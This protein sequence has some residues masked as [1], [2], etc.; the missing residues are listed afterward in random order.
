MR[1]IRW[2]R[3]GCP[4]PPSTGA[5]AWPP[6]RSHRR[7]RGTG[8]RADRVIGESCDEPID[9]LE[10]R[11][12]GDVPERLEGLERA[13]LLP[14]RL[15]H[16]LAA[17]PDVGVPE[18]RGAVE[19]APA[20]VV[21]EVDALAARDHELV[22]RDGRHVGERVPVRAGRRQRADRVE[23]SSRRVTLGAGAAGVK[24]EP[25]AR[26][27][28]MLWHG[29]AGS[30]ARALRR[31]AR[32]RAAHALAADRARGGF[33]ARARDRGAVVRFHAGT[34][35]GGRRAGWARSAPAP[36]AARVERRAARQRRRAPRGGHPGHATARARRALLPRGRAGRR[37]DGRRGLGRRGVREGQRVPRH[38]ARRPARHRRLAGARLPAG[39][40]AG[41]GRRRCCGVSAPLLR[42][43]RAR[44]T[45]IHDGD[46]RC[47]SRTCPAAAR[48][49][50][51]RHL[52]QL[53]RRHA[54]AGSI[55]AASRA[56][57]APRRSTAASL[58][59][60]PVYEL[61]ARNA[62]RALRVQ[63]AR[64]R[65][66]P[67]LPAGFPDTRA[68]LARVLARHPRTADDLATAIAVLLRSPEDAARVP[69]LVHEAA[70]GRRGAAGSREFAAHVGTR[71]RRALAPA[72]VLDHDP[73]N[74]RWARFDVAATA[75]RAAGAILA[76]AAVARAK[77]FRQA[78][79]AVP[80]AGGRGRA[81]RS[82]PCRPCRSCCSRATPIRR[83]RRRT[84]AGW[85]AD[86]PQRPARQ[87]ARPGARRDRL[88]LPA[89]PRRAL[90]RRAAAPAGST[91]AARGACRCRASSSASECAARTGR[92]RAAR[93]PRAGRDP[94][95]G[96]RA[97]HA[98]GRGD[99]ERSARAVDDASGDA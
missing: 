86:V 8:T 88:R 78:C 92:A 45:P 9:E 4:W 10:R 68:E 80:R 13:Q 57:C 99:E 31:A 42:A 90:R 47:R 74:E 2:M 50:P 64:C 7:R 59:S 22:A 71:A 39:A 3:S 54:R 32:R 26:L 37:G 46:R 16:V 91:R 85:R 20:L 55:C 76:H 36:T 53:L 41:D 82:E 5:R 58:P 87:R 89:P 14:D 83:I 61:A 98:D 77:L 17:V 51:H 67:G 23:G 97:E 69:L 1:L 30:L 70:A 15:G 84:C 18:A 73:C 48:L 35:A 19:V 52:R 75:R 72:D 63:I 65:A 11:R 62:E 33:A 94:E 49:R 6:C 95:R 96:D 81:A 40:R 44:G 25:A 66:Q 12:V 27:C 28:Y 93:L 79:A 60:M 34:P 29:T 38:R 21:P 56:R 43:P 24:L